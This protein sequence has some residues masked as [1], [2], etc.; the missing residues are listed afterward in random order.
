[1]KPSDQ[2]IREESCIRLVMFEYISHTYCVQKNV[3]MQLSLTTYQNIITI[4]FFEQHSTYQ[5]FHSKNLD[6]PIFFERLY[7]A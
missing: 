2:T 3:F 5:G 1:M 7:V 4:T 6:S